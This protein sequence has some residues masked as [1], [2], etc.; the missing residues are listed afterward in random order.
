MKKLLVSALFIF[1]SI[2]SIHACRNTLSNNTSITFKVAEI[3]QNNELK[4]QLV[5]PDEYVNDEEKARTLKPGEETDFG[6]HYLPKYVIYKEY[7][8]KK[9]RPLLYVKQVRCA[10]DGADPSRFPENK[11]LL[12]TDLL[13]QQLPDDYQEVYSFT[14]KAQPS[15][16]L[17]ESVN[18]KALTKIDNPYQE[19]V[20][21]LDEF[22]QKMQELF[23][24]VLKE[25]PRKFKSAPADEKDEKA[26]CTMCKTPAAA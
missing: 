16:L 7:T 9:W 21:L 4:Q 1:L 14:V 22:T 13:K 6:G 17:V 10:P 20:R 12:I 24:R 3:K 26:E 8:D 23:S 19:A 25:Q 18:E 2:N 5:L 15:E 11:Y